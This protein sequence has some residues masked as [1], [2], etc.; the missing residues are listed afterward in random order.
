MRV[1]I[2]YS[3]SSTVS[4]DEMYQVSVLSCTAVVLW[5]NILLL[6]RV[7]SLNSQNGS[8]EG[9]PVLGQPT[10]HKTG[11]VVYAPTYSLFYA[12]QYLKP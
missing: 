7:M 4:V 11:R 10:N 2:R 6:C 3:P 1:T 12:A 9:C 5:S 8:F